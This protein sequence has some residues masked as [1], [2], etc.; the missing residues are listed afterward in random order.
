[1]ISVFSSD[2]AILTQTDV[3]IRNL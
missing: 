2:S 3:Q 1:M